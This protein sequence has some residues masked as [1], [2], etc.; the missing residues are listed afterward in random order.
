VSLGIPA[1]LRSWRKRAPIHRASNEAAKDHVNCARLARSNISDRKSTRASLY[2]ASGA[3]D[4][5][6]LYLEDRRFRSIGIRREAPRDNAPARIGADLA[7]GPPEILS[8]LDSFPSTLRTN[9]RALS[10]PWPV[11]HE[12]T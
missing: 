7:R 12:K 5:N 9:R 6:I 10:P 4:A 11:P 1:P 8:Y 3:A 2:R